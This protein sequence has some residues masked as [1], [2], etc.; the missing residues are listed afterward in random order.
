MHNRVIVETSSIVGKWLVMKLARVRSSGAELLSPARSISDLLLQSGTQ[1]LSY[2]MLP[3]DLHAS[4]SWDTLL[5]LRRTGC[6]ASDYR[7]EV[8]ALW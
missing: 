3:F 8:A 6:D 1:V 4:H 7:H 2:G 5:Q